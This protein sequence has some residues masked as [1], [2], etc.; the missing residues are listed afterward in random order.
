MPANATISQIKLPSGTTYDIKD[1]QAREDI[2]SIEQKIV[3]GTSWVGTT[4]TPLA[5]KATAAVIVING[6]DH[7]VLNGDIAQYGNSEFIA[8]VTENG[9]IKTVVWDLFGE[10]GSFGAL[11][12]K[13]NASGNVEVTGT[14]I[15]GVF[16][17]TEATISSSGTTAGVAV[18]DISYTPAGSITESGSVDV[19]VVTGVTVTDGTAA[20]FVQGEDV[21][22]TTVTNEVLEIGFTQGT[23][24]YTAGTPTAVTSSNTTIKNMNNASYS[25]T[26]AAATLQH[27]VTQGTV[28]A[29][30]TYTPAGT[31]AD[32]AVTASGNVTVS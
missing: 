31:V 13:D 7:T 11:A 29:S 9:G 12:F 24:T 26:G 14:A 27:S 20:T 15:G 1:A 23:D 17:G 3:N 18:D 10:A 8:T 32:S 2:S 30:A 19:T 6:A 4:T 21:L 22:T 25:F 28:T 16:T 5:D